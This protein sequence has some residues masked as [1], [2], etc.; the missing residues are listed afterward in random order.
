MSHCL[1]QWLG[2]SVLNR[3]CNQSKHM[4]TMAHSICRV[5]IATIAVPTQNTMDHCIKQ[6]I[7]VYID[8]TL[9]LVRTMVYCMC[10]KQT[11]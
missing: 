3:Y 7:I 4:E 11:P 5:Y 8:E 1:E 9:G 2:V 10:L 6:K